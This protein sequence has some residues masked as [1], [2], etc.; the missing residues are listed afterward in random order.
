M[1]ELYDQ[2][3]TSLREKAAV[4]SVQCAFLQPRGS[5]Q[6]TVITGYITVVDAS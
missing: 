2:E 5:I 1:P 6:T 3:I 4:F